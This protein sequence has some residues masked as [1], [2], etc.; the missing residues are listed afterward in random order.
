MK[1]SDEKDSKNLK[2]LGVVNVLD[3]ALI[4]PSSFEDTTLI[5]TPQNGAVG[6]V[7]VEIK[8]HFKKPNHLAIQTFCQTWQMPLHLIIF[9]PK[10]FHFQS[11]KSH[12]T[13]Y[14][15]GKVEFGFGKWQMVQPKIITKIDTIIPRYKT[16][17]KNPTMINLVQKYISFDNLIQAGLS[18]KNAQILSTLHCGN[19][20]SVE[21]MSEKNFEQQVLPA[22]KYVE[23]FNYLQKLSR[24][25]VEFP[26]SS[27]LCGDEKP[28]IKSLPFKLTND[29]K[30]AICDIKRDL[31]SSI[32]SKRVIMGDVGCGKTM[33]I[34][35]SVMMA[36][37]KRAILMAPTTILAKQIYEEAKKFLPLH[38]KVALVT[39][40]EKKASLEEFHFIIG[41]HALLY[42]TLPQCD[43]VMIDEQ[44]RF[45]TKQRKLIHSLV[46]QDETHPHFLQFTATPIPRTLSLINA[47]VVKYSFIK[48]LPFPKDIMTKVIEKADFKELLLHIENEISKSHQTI[49][50][51]PLV[52]ESENMVY[53]SLEEGRGFW[54]KRYKKV[55]VT[56]GKDKDKERVLE[57]FRDGGN[58]LLAT[59]VVEVGISLP[60]LSTIVIVGAERLGLASLHQLRGR[61]SR[62]GLKGYCYLFTYQKEPL[63]LEEFSKTISGFKIAELDLKYRQSGDLLSG[64]MQHGEQFRYFDMR[65]DEKILKEAKGDIN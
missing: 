4:I 30:S 47:T 8:S 18:Q 20:K 48:E 3:L 45:G 62:T 31:E 58:I 64:A 59:T 29:Q 49:I 6:S 50:I 13:L 38:V 56:H 44:H 16:P 37:P 28:F 33:V 52:E 21:L 54:E 25:K 40:K 19:K 43:L 26:S 41:T 42:K 7:C 2:R 10:P 12:A 14:V 17:L 15:L 23:I 36:Y 11:F 27:K 55:F 53:Q 51:Y 35:A 9:H 34:F 60:K 5:K 57:E 65:E 1:S 39:S 46:S 22:L 61:V 63:R 32:A 24:K